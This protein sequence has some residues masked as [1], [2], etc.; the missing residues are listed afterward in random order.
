MMRR[1]AGRHWSW[2]IVVVSVFAL[3]FLSGCAQTPHP[4]PPPAPVSGP[5]AKPAPDRA[6]APTVRQDSAATPESSL[7]G[8]G[9][10]GRG[11]QN[12]SRTSKGPRPYARVITPAAKTRQGLFITHQ[13][14]DKLYFEIPRRELNKDMLLVGRYAQASAAGK[15]I[16]GGDK[17]S[18][19]TLR[20]ER[21]GDRIFIRS[22]SFNVSADP[23]QPIYRA[24]MQANHY[25]ILTVFDIESFGPD[26]A[27]VIEVSSLY[28]S[29]GKPF[30]ALPDIDKKRTF[31]ERVASFPDNVEIEATQT[32]GGEAVSG[33]RAGSSPE[34][35]V[36]HWSMIRL[37]ERPMM[38]RWFDERVGY[39]SDDQVDFSAPGHHFVRRKYAVRW[40]LEKKDPQA[41]LSEPV[42]PIV[43]YI[44]PATPDV[45][46]PW[47]KHGVE[48]WQSAF[49]AAGFKNAILAK[50]PPI[51]DPDWSPEDVRH[52][53]VRWLPSTSRN[54]QGPNIHDPR[55]GEILNGSIRMFHGVLDLVRN[56]YF[57]QVGPLDPRA[58]QFPFP[59]SLT[60]RLLAFVV[61]HEV[62]HTLGLRHN[63][64]GSSL[65]PA[66]S[67]R[68]RTWVAKMGHSPSIM[69]YARFNYVAQPED[70]ISLNDLI[71]RIG[72]Y[73]KFAIAW[74]YKPIPEARTPHAEWSTLDSWAQVQDTVPWLR[75]AES[76]AGDYS[77]HTEAVGDQNPVSSTG[78]GLKN[79]QRVIQRIPSVAIVP[80]QDNGLLKDL[81]SSVLGQW[82]MEMKHVASV[83]AGSEYQAKSGGQPGA[84]Y[85]PIA[86]Q[87]QA[88]AV[89]FLN[90][91]VFTTPTYLIDSRITSRLEPGGAVA[92]LR[93]SQQR[94]LSE[95]LTGSRIERLIEYEVLARPGERVYTA[96]DLLSDLRR[97]IWTELS[98]SRPAIDV[99][100]RNLQ[101]SYLEIAA[102]L[103]E[104][105]RESGSSDS[106]AKGTPTPSG[107]SSAPRGAGD[108]RP[109][110]RG[111]LVMLRK[112]VSAAIPR[113]KDT[114]S[115]LHLEDVQVEIDRILDRP[116]LATGG[117][118]R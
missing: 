80:G 81:Y 78:Y 116:P 20:W 13:I 105:E 89:R 114:M 100:R 42:E 54:A 7:E 98:A 70:S 94:V 102:Q 39:F 65:Y 26:S 38:Q 1:W 12:A 86:R 95:L 3:D 60:G 29:F 75:F 72:P 99:Y 113:A 107:E 58:Q 46:K 97:G 63:Q 25:P 15:D 59:D 40:R 92:R 47:I 21:N 68:S 61:A 49:E 101:R 35:V 52:T 106:K 103:I 48:I 77:V 74:G 31:I 34:T 5:A 117:R 50:E 110:L 17:F 41:A 111:E 53:V 83:V 67:V 43:Y 32:G 87:Q 22:P 14:D 84:V 11:G 115:R 24:V 62:G 79:I 51:G 6:S 44:D 28:T 45:W 19:A 69:D 66:D 2:R 109:L 23:A 56:W 82:S 30:G 9:A 108:A 33:G 118:K 90:D 57:T 96:T 76:E 93:S 64:K 88:A 36:A 37:P 104:P 18:E 16:Y 112:A 27:P 91:N 8:D 85:S 73:D 10:S 71:P 4:Q 55:T